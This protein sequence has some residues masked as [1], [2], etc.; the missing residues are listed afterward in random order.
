M[1]KWTYIEPKRD[2]KSRGAWTTASLLTA[3]IAVAFWLPNARLREETAVA[4]V[5]AAREPTWQL[6]R[7]TDRLD[8]TSLLEVSKAAT[9]TVKF[10]PRRSADHSKKA[11]L[12]FRCRDKSTE[13]MFYV[14]QTLVAG[15]RN[16]V[17]YRF[18][19]RP[20]TKTQSWE[21]STDNAAVGI[22][23]SAPAQAFIR[24]AMESKK[25]LFRTETTVFG[26]TEA[27]F[28]LTGLGE[29]IKPVREACKW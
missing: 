2:G 25:L 19:A 4:A 26:I 3:L 17:I 22:W 20:P 12:V 6:R 21:H 28:D 10:E 11:V 16:D 27:E 29:A 23:S 1:A 8:D 18:D 9:E 5:G 7:A 15:H 14:P 24:R 13:A